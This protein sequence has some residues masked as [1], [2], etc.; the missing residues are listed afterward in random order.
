MPHGH[1]RARRSLCSLLAL[2]LSGSAWGAEDSETLAEMTVMARPLSPFMLQPEWTS[3]AETNTAFLLRR[4]PG[5]NI[6]FN[7][8][9][10]GLPQYRGL[11]GSRVNVLVD[12]INIGNACANNMD[13]P[14]HYL[15]RTSLESLEVIRGIAPVSSGMETIGGTVIADGKLSRFTGSAEYEVHGDIGLGGQSVDAGY[16]ASGRVSLANDTQRFHAGASRERGDDRH[17]GSGEIRPTS[18][19]RDAWELGY[20]LRAGTHEFGL[21]YRRNDTGRTG[22][23]ALPMDDIYSD[24][25]IGRATYGGLWGPVDIEARGYLTRVDHRMSNYEMRTLPAGRPARFN[26]AEADSGGWFVSGTFDLARGRLRLGTDGQLLQHDSN[27]YDPNNAGF[28]LNSFNGVRRDRFSVY[29]EWD[30]S[31]ADR[32][33]LQLGL[34][35]TRVDMDAG[36]VDASMARM[37]PAGPLAQ[38]RNAFNAAGRSRADDNVEAVVKLIYRMRQDLSLEF[39]LARKVRSPT[40][41]ERYLWAPLEAT[42]GLADGRVYIGNV[43]LEPETA[44]QAELGLSF[45]GA[46]GRFSPRAFYH[47]V[48]DYI[49]G[50]PTNNMAAIMVARMM[51]G[52]PTA[53]PL[54][55]SNVGARLYG[56]DAEWGVALSEHWSLDG[57]VSYVRGERTDTADNLYRI[58]PLNALVDLSYRREVWS[59]TLESVWYA[60]QDEVSRVNDETKSPGYGL[61]NVYGQYTLPTTGLTFS[62]GVE[63]ILDK[64][65]RPHLNG[66]NRVVGT[67]VPVGTRIPGDGI[68]AFLQASLRF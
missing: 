66:F 65:Y 51:S 16:A 12:G 21:D 58:S 26:L 10:A 25:D 56:F 23:P 39:G 4:I 57:L 50:T 68:N 34:R 15:P 14:L 28:F 53:V 49:Q 36:T 55:F 44:Y 48:D 2:G 63:N 61:L 19:R 45:T 67:D 43:S 35:Y 40:Y 47:H 60:A 42:G 5:A 30:R 22:T 32:W 54:E 13:A 33:D 18:Y 59:I 46:R 64:T 37:M 24:A 9:L 31:F 27:I 17:F 8:T 29:G 1:D 41:Q 20:G 52:D 3:L 38:L 62:A 7:G 11:F 6:N